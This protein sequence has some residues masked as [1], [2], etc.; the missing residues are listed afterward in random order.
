MRAG[1]SRVLEVEISN[2]G[3]ARADAHTY[4]ADVYTLVNGGFGGRLRED[5]T[6]GTT[7][8]LDYEP[9]VLD[10]APGDRLRR[11]FTVTVPADAGPGEYITSL[12]LETELPAQADAAVGARQIQRQAL[13][14]VVTVPGTRSPELEVG[15]ASHEYAAGMSVLSIAVSNTG[16]VRTQPTVQL[17]LRSAGGVRLTEATVQMDSFYAATDTTVELPLDRPLSAGSYSI[18]VVAAD[19]QQGVES[20]SRQTF[21]IDRADPVALIGETPLLTTTM[22]VAG[23]QVPVLLLIGVLGAVTMIA[24]TMR[25]ALGRHHGMRRS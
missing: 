20:T 15:N 16:N 19:V 25:V 7:R 17:I 11:S 13:G 1:T 22:D 24:G 6:S 23:T 5:P 10:L 12:V 8:W 9:D 18:D 4:A 2:D 21:E 14:V 3:S